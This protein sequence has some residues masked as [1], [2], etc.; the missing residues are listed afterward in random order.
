MPKTVTTHSARHAFAD[1]ARRA[2]VE[3]EIISRLLGHS[4]GTMTA[5]YGSG[6]DLKALHEAVCAVRYEGVK[7]T[8]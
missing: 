6:Y 5:R 2:K 4:A 3:P 8:V 7:L 1:A